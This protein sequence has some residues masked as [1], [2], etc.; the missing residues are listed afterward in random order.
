MFAHNKQLLKKTSWTFQLLKQAAFLLG[1]PFFQTMSW[2]HSLAAFYQLWSTFSNKEQHTNQSLI[3]YQ[4]LGIIINGNE[5]FSQN[6][7]I[8]NGHI[9]CFIWYHFKIVIL[10][11][12]DVQNRKCRNRPWKTEWFHK[13]RNGWHLCK[14]LAKAL[15]RLR[16]CAGWTEPLLVAQ[17]TLLEISCRCSFITKPGLCACRSVFCYAKNKLYKL[18]F[19]G[20]FSISEKLS[21]YRF[22]FFGPYKV[23]IFFIK[24]FK[25]T[26]CH[27]PSNFGVPCLLILKCK[28]KPWHRWS[29]WVW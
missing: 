22:Q 29:L 21:S 26:T 2:V 7:C 10:W 19:S 12:F 23:A 3:Y 5:N 13:N 1:K 6:W 8:G 14:R 11:N 18:L 27:A 24:T 17:T 28:Y 20:N 4:C 25:S 9:L 16:I 15:I